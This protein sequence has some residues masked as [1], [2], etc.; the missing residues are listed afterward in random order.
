MSPFDAP[1]LWLRCALHAHTTN[2]DGEL[3]PDLLVRHY[4]WAGYDVLAITD[5][6]VRTAVALDRAVARH[7]LDRAERPRARPAERRPRPRPGSR[8]RPGDSGARLRPAP[9]GC[10]VDRRARRRP[11]SRAHLLERPAHGAVGGVRGSPRHRGVEHRVRARARTRRFVVALGRGTRARARVL[12]ARHR[13]LTSPR[14]RQRLRLDV[15]SRRGEVAGARCST[16]CA[17]V[18]STARP[19]R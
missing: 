5:H 1:G 15:G 9:G 3:A 18:R 12:R 16:R 17:P 4:E 13:R 2:S 10:R 14:L 7:P 8:S 19:A 11:L 6:W